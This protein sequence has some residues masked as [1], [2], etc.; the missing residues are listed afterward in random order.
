MFIVKAVG[1][2]MEPRI[3]DGDY[4]V[5]RANPSGSREGKIV[6]VQHHNY[7]DAEY[8]GAYSIKK[9]SSSKIYDSQ[10]N[11]KHEAIELIP[12][13]NQYNPIIINE[14]DGE[15]FRIVGELIGIL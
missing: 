4:C 1:N 5:F 3:H 6:L 10:G 13:N 7:Y 12:L 2:S 15:D 14:E 8:S 9:Y 11:W